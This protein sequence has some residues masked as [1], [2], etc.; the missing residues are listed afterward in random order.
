MARRRSHPNRR[1]SAAKPLYFASTVG[2]VAS[3]AAMV[4]AARAANL[5]TNAGFEAGTTTTA[6]P[7]SFYGGE[8][9]AKRESFEAHSGFFG[10][11]EQTFDPLGGTRQVINNISAGTPYTLT[12]WQ[13]FETNYPTSTVTDLKLTWN[14]PAA[15]VNTLNIDGTTVTTGVWTQFTLNATAPAGAT[16]VT[17]S[18]DWTN[19]VNTGLNGQSV[20]VDDA[21]LEGAGI[22]PTTATWVINGSGDWNVPGNWSTGT[23]PTGA[24]A[25]ADLLGII[26]ANHNVYSDVPIT[27]GTIVF[28]N[29]NT[30]VI[31]G[32]G[33]MTLQASTGAAQVTLQAQVSPNTQKINLPLTIASN[34]V[35]NVPS[36]CTL[37]ISDPVTINS[38]MSLTQNGAGTVSYESTITVL[39]GGSIAFSSPSHAASLSLGSTGTAS[40]ASIAMH[41]MGSGPTI[42]Q[43]DAL[44][45]TNGAST[46]STLDLSN[47]ELIVNAS[48]ATVRGYITGKNLITSVSNDALG[49]V[50]LGNGQ[51]EV[52]A[53]LLGDSD[54]NGIVNVADL[55]NLA[56]NF[57]KT[58]GQE[59]LQGDFDYNGTVNV[60]DLA[61]LA[62][63]FGQSAINFDASASPASAVS[64][65]STVPE[66]AGLAI[67]CIGAA[68]ALLRRRRDPHRRE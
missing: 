39:G 27:V 45:F 53:T 58:S 57:G 50:N 52:R 29:T 26:S 60:A 17:V 11:W 22:P 51:T 4:P 23:V 38:G 59:W 9:N 48:T 20:F 1:R 12:D 19:G 8:S 56:G 37:K 36:T 67:A 49:Y 66:P 32:A 61:D 44:S 42:L 10:F 43:L 21:D 14:D 3:G 2:L 54:L 24:G 7:W 25:E 35:L 15:T 63:N 30:Y 46:N 6:P 33:S 16:S 28:G 55:A 68:T 18:F 31:D 62:G 13:W 65:A 5:L 40:T 34:T 47:N 41:A 64:A